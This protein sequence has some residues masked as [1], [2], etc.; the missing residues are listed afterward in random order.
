MRIS[1]K[2]LA[3]F[4]WTRH[5]AR[6]REGMSAV[7]F[8]LVVPF[9]IS[10]YLGCVEVGNTVAISL[11]TTLVARTV[12]DLAS[13]FV[14]VHNSDM[15]NILNAASVVMAPYSGTP[16]SVVVA[17]ITTN[18]SGNGTVTWSDTLNGTALTVGAAFSLPTNLRTPNISLIWAQANYAYTPNL[19]VVVTGTIHLT[20]QA[21]MYP[22]LANTVSRTS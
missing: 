3:A 13:Q 9:M 22:R 17:E 6:D 8:A 15:T 19:G 10:A 2:H 5:F 1:T 7:E 12:A 14:Y 4:K 21:Y 16:L 20:D 18:S 11:R